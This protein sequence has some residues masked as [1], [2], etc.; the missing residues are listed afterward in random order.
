MW[1]HLVYI[2]GPE[3]RLLAGEDERKVQTLHSFNCRAAWVL[4]MQ[5]HAIQVDQ[6]TCHLSTPNRDVFDGPPIELV[7][8]TLMT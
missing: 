2:L 4:Q 5:T 3:I 1:S 8:H 7:H 6:C